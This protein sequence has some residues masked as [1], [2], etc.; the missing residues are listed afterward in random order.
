MAQFCDQ[1]AESISK[2]QEIIDK[3]K[4]E[5]QTM[6]KKLAK[7]VV[8]MSRQLTSRQVLHST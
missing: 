6:L 3:N 5:V 1:S 8:D 4:T 2:I 7:V